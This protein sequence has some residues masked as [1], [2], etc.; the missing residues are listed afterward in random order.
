MNVGFWRWI[1]SKIGRLILGFL[2]IGGWI[3]IPMTIHLI[4]LRHYH[5][6]EE[7]A[8]TILLWAI[9]LILNMAYIWYIEDMANE[10]LDSKNR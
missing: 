3:F 8:W 4:L 10:K 6:D 9:P 1:G 2:G 7:F 5:I